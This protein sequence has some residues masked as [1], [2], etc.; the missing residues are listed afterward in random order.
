M[1]EEI[2]VSDEIML[3]DYD[4]KYF[5]DHWSLVTN[6][7]VS[8]FTTFQVYKVPQDLHGYI[9]RIKRENNK[10]P[11]YS[12]R[13]NWS[14]IDTKND[15]FLGGINL[16]FN[17][18]QDAVRMGY[19]L[20]E[21]YWDKGIMTSSVTAVI[22]F[23]KKRYPQIKVIYSDINTNNIRSKR[24]LEKNGFITDGKILER[25]NKGEMIPVLLYYK[26]L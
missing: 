22:D 25:K 23:I 6:P 14:I 3:K 19:V 15:K 8:Y 16:L 26:D 9:N 13:L 4:K 2:K 7:N 12:N 10:F 20:N 24:V 1:I 17:F 5:N 18:K 11:D 21:P